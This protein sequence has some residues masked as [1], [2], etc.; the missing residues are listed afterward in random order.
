MKPTALIAEDEALARRKLRD[1]LAALDVVELVGEAADGLTC[2]RALDELEPDVLFLDVQMPGCDGFEVL[3]R[4]HHRPLTIFTTAYDQFAV[5]AFE[6]AAVDYLLKPFGPERLRVALDRALQVVAAG[7]PAG[8]EDRL[9]AT[10]G[11]RP[12]S[13]LFVRDRGRIV[14]I[15]PEAIVRIE[16]QDDYAAV[17]TADRRYLVHLPLGVLEQRLDAD[18]FARVHRSHIVN[19]DHVVALEP[20]DSTRLEVVLRDGTRV[21]ASRARSRALR[22]RAD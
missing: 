12:V 10:W 21:L 1:L 20:Y 22:A 4:A 11:R 13:R 18:R 2:V 14:P 19:L 15:S 3:A 5:A 8:A 7:Q 16:A 6:M 17:H 9:R